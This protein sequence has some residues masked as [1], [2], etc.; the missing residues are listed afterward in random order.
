MQF[1]ENYADAIEDYL[2]DKLEKVGYPFLWCR[3]VSD[4]ETSDQR[5]IASSG[6]RQTGSRD[7]HLSEQVS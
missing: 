1:K 2:Q 5:S 3:L 4:G 6:I 7:N